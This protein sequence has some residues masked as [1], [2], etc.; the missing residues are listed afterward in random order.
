MLFITSDEEKVLLVSASGDKAQSEGYK[1]GKVVSA[2][3]KKLGGGGGG[4]DSF[5]T[6]GGKNPSAIEE[7][8]RQLEE[9]LPQL[10]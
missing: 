5:A 7:T 10:S 8:L 2:I 3:A 6:A 9:F 4:R 1:S